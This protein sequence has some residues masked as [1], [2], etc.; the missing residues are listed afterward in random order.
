MDKIEIKNA[1]IAAAKLGFEEKGGLDCWVFLDYGGTGQ[2]FGGLSLYLPKGFKHFNLMSPAGHFIYR[3]ME[4]AGV[5]KWNELVGKSVRV[6][7]SWGK[8]F[9][10]GN[11]VKDDWFCPEEDFKSLNKSEEP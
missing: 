4:V 7:R 2:G 9:A 1:I 8:V 6:K 11:I 10:L 5:E 3:T